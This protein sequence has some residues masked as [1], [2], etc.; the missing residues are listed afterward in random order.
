MRPS[1]KKDYASFQ[2]F[3]KVQKEVEKAVKKAKRKLERSLAKN[4]KKNPKAFYSYMKKKTSNK[5]TVGPLKNSDGRLVTDDKEMADILNSHYCNMFTKE[6]M[7]SMP[8]VEKLYQGEDFLSSVNFTSENV[9]AKL[10]KLRPTAAPGP[11][12]V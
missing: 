11:D 4:S 7:A 1:H 10:K 9:T 8:R 5:V 3:K 6:N 2:A 12:K